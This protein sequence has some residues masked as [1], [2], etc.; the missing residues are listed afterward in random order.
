MKDNESL[1]RPSAFTQ[2]VDRSVLETQVQLALLLFDSRRPV[3]GPAFPVEVFAGL[4]IDLL[5][6]RS[7]R[8][9]NRCC[10]QL[11]DF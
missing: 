3:Q 6:Y 2:P 4:Y 11:Y 5:C 7:S 1:P 10:M 9:V 8:L